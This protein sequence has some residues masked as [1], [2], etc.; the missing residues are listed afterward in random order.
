M[1]ARA[2]AEEFADA[3]TDSALTWLDKSL[4]RIPIEVAATGPKVIAA[5]ARYA[6]NIAFALGADPQR[7]SWGL[8][9]ARTAREQAG[10]EP[11]GIGLAAYVNVVCHPDIGQARAIANETLATFARF[12]VM[13]GTVTGPLPENERNM[14]AGLNRAFNM[15]EHAYNTNLLSDRLIDRF[16]IVGPAQTCIRRLQAIADLG[17]EKVIVVGPWASVGDVETQRAEEE[18]AAHV[19]PA[20]SSS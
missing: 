9:Q 1:A 3:P 13:N 20:F 5:A 11:E 7:L 10:L 6:D 8:Q 18:L 2:P 19:L 16:A 4:P 17:I 14:L 12:S 15:R